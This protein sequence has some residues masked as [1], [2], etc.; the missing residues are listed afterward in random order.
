M[1][2][3]GAALPFETGLPACHRAGLTVLQRFFVG[4]GCGSVIVWGPACLRRGSYLTRPYYY[5]FARSWRHSV[6]AQVPLQFS[7][8]PPL[9]TSGCPTLWG[10]SMV[11]IGKNIANCSK[12]PQFLPVMCA[13]CPRCARCACA[14]HTYPQCYACINAG[15]FP[16]FWLG[17]VAWALHACAH[18]ATTSPTGPSLNALKTEVCEWTCDHTFLHHKTGQTLCTLPPIWAHMGHVL[19]HPAHEDMAWDF[20]TACPLQLSSGIFMDGLFM[21]GC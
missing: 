8:A 19:A 18:S 10:C 6:T 13:L 2:H 20:V 17:F 5:R 7:C 21:D 16:P 11:C 14:V 15:W 9:Q 12:K 1:P 3:R 4:F